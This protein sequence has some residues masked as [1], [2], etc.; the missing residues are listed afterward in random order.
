MPEVFK[1]LELASCYNE[2]KKKKKNLTG[3][4]YHFKIPIL[5]HTNRGG[6]MK[7][8]TLGKY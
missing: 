8:C 5:A 7:L 1:P 2:Q 4:T 3:T 6:L